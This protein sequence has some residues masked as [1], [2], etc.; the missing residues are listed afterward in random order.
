MSKNSTGILAHDIEK[1][2]NSVWHK[3]LVHKMLTL[4][5]PRCIT[6]L[7]L[8]FFSNRSF[9]VCV[10]GTNS[11]PYKIVAGVPQG[12][13]LSPTLFNIFTSDLIISHCEKGM[14]ADDT[15]IQFPARSPGKIL[16]KI[17]SAR[18]YLTID[19]NGNWNWTTLR[20]RRPSS[21]VEK[22]RN[23]SLRMKLLLLVSVEK[24]M[25]L[26]AVL[27]PL[28]NRKSKLNV[29]N[30]LTVYTAIIRNTLL[31]ACPVWKWVSKWSTISLVTFPV[32]SFIA[33][34]ICRL[35]RSRLWKLLW[36]LKGNYR[37]RLTR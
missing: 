20:R 28:L 26:L 14:V 9:H 2:F 1:A 8:S 36:T 37:Y 29:P 32:M 15:T 19:L 21:L 13:V 24:A 3:G 16:K 23:G 5:L 34:L 25:R 22:L 12:S 31:Y 11:K 35:S 7:V 18:N 33:L 4:K 17:N 6:K 27:Y 10:N 30:E